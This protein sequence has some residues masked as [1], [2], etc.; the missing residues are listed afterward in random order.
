VD[1]GLRCRNTWETIVS[2]EP[3]LEELRRP[4]AAETV[5]AHQHHR[6]A[7]C[8]ERRLGQAL[9]L[10]CQWDREEVR[11]GGKLFEEPSPE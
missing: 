4:T 7:S 2:L 11:I 6:D 8:L 3:S 1:D 10:A 9:E 5:C